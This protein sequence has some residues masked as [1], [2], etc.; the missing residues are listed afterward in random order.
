MKKIILIF[1]VLFLIFSVY[2]ENNY[3]IDWVSGKIF[4]TVS[5]TSKSDYNFADKKIAGIEKINDETKTGFYKALKNLNVF[6]TESVLDYFEKDAEKNRELHTLID[7]AKLFKLEYPGFNSIRLTYSIN[8]YGEDSLMGLI[9]NGSNYAEELKS[10][11]DYPFHADYTG[12]IIDARG[13]L[14]TFNGA[15]V[16]VL[17]SLFM[18]IKDSEGRILFDK[19]NILPEA[20]KKNGMA[21]YSYDIR[22]D[23]S[24]R[25][26]TN[27]FRVVACGA[28]DRTGSV[29]VV[30]ESDAKKILSS[31]LLKNAIQHG[32]I[33]FIINQ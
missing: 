22:E 2:A 11:M 26:G 4:S 7:N 17:P 33:A 30:S 15:K 10:Y 19:D 5:L 28:G 13:E 24:S 27:P 23:L 25:V 8:I 14:T 31:E 1:S 3:K 9:S 21:R 18:T 16:K 29:V 12:L 6:G 32:N 20:I